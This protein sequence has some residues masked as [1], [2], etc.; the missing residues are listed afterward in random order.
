MGI[1]FDPKQ[2][3]VSLGGV[4]LHG[5]VPGTFIDIAYNAD[6]AATVVG[7]DGEVTRVLISDDSATMTVTLQAQSESNAFLAALR[8]RDKLSGDGIVQCQVKDGMNSEVFSAMA[9]VQ[10]PPGVGYAGG[11]ESPERAWVIGLG[12]ATLIVTPQE[13][14]TIDIIGDLPNLLES[15]F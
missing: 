6:D 7:A 1:T 4:S 5:F 2:V 14:P 10:A 11:G 12:E 9:W 3:S 8:A 13:I 15:I